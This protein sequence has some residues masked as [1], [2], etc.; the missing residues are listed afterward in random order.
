MDT[1]ILQHMT[2]DS[3]KCH[4]PKEYINAIVCMCV[5]V[6]EILA[7]VSMPFLPVL[8]AT[9]YYPMARKYRKNYK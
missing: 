8:T 4:A 5:C 1:I 6:N 3:G 2:N 7:H 9:N